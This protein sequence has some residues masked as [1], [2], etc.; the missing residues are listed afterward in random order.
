MCAMRRAAG[1]RV[2]AVRV[3]LLL[4]AVLLLA[5]ALRSIPRLASWQTIDDARRLPAVVAGKPVDHTYMVFFPNSVL[6]FDIT[7]VQFGYLNIA[8]P[9]TMA[10]LFLVLTLRSRAF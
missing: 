10:V 7:L 8:L 4:Q 9:A 5:L 2:T 1:A 3:L 6:H